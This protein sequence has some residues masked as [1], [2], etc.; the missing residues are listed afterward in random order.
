MSGPTKVLTFALLSTIIFS[1]AP[2]A[3]A[4][5][6]HYVWNQ[7]YETLPQGS[8][9]LEGST[10]LK[11]PQFKQSNENEWEYQGELE[12]GLTDHWNIAH[13]ERWETD[14]KAAA[15][16]KDVTKYSGFKFETKYRLGEKGKYWADPLL[17]LEISRDPRDK[18]IPMK[19]EG[20]IVLSKDFGKF[21][22]TYNQMMESGLGTSGRTE[23]QFTTGLNYEL[24]SG[25]RLGVETLGQYWNPTGHRNEL[26]MGPTF[27]YET[28]WFWLAIGS[29][30][31]LNH[32]AD[33]VQARV[34]V[35]VPF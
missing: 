19:I 18:D 8:F 12:Y 32:A 27:A 28:K 14:N 3:F 10:T 1:R 26:A 6:R 25:L 21:N 30:F 17:Y 5:V 9:E 23:H 33:D 4:H 20:K 29:L 24:I 15:D 13:Y 11:V 34:L 2:E 7:V 22:V 31:G 35:G 16:E